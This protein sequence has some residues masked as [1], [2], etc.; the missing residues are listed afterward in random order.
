MKTT[1]KSVGSGE[2]LRIDGD[3]RMKTIENLKK[4][5]GATDGLFWPFLLGWFILIIGVCVLIL[6]S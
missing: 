1:I 5:V 4:D 6:K 2:T 3:Q